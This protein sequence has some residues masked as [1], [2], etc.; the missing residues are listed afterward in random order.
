MRIIGHLDMDA[1]FAAIEER[2]SP[3][4]KGKPIVVG[5]DP[6]KGKGR[7]VVSTANYKARQYGIYSGMPISRAW[8]LAELGKS[9]GKKE[10]IFVPGDHERY[11]EISEKIFS[12]LKHRAKIIEQAGIDEAYFDLS[13]MGS[14]GRAEML[15]KSLKK[16]IKKQERLTCSVGIGPNKLIAKIASDFKK[17]DGLTVV[18]EDDVQTFLAPLPVRR[19]PGIGPKTEV[20]FKE[21]GIISVANLRK[22][23]QLEL[24]VML[25]KWGKELYDKVR[26]I[27]NSPLVT[28]WKAKSVS[29]QETFIADIRDPL[30]VFDHLK[31]L[32]RGAHERMIEEGFKKFK[33]ISIKIRFADFETMT[34]ANTLRQ[35]TN[36]LAT[37]EFEA[38][39]MMMPF[40]DRRENPEEKAIRLIG[41]KL[42]KLS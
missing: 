42:D 37:L 25:G 3:Q 34:R 7:G 40:L 28:A 12:I 16:E 36:S 38:M 41:V 26:G 31:N 27:D 4:F 39:K 32:C 23:P 30:F 10:I 35:P 24:E 18:K 29:E 17:P 13:D 21:R 11:E 9:Q 20:L 8:R 6:L 5:A 1:F 33:N 15:C 2:N 19:I 22:L 14:Y